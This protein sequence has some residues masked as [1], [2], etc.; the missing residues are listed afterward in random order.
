MP[1]LTIGAGRYTSS[2]ACVLHFVLSGNEES[3][4]GE[5][6]GEFRKVLH[7]E[8]VGTRITHMVQ[9]HDLWNT[10]YGILTS[11]GYHTPL[12]EERAKQ[13]SVALDLLMHHISAEYNETFNAREINDISKTNPKDDPPD[14]ITYRDTV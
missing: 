5:P 4:L 9:L 6:T 7:A 8:D 12:E 1:S 14:T 2:S 11:P 10:A 3:M 13:L